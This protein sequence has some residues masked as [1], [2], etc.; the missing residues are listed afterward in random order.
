M[1]LDH[2][3]IRHDLSDLS[4]PRSA[5]G[6]VT[7]AL[8]QRKA[9]GAKAFTV[10]SCD[11]LPSNGALARRILLEFAERVSPDLAAWI[12]ANATFPATM[13]D[14]ITPATTED[15]VARLS[16]EQGYNDLGAVAHEAFRQWVIEDSFADGRPAWDQ[17]GATMVASVEDHELMKLRCL[18]G[19]HST[20]AYLGYL[21]GYET[22]ADCV[23]DPDFAALCEKLWR[24]EIT[25]FLVTPVGENLTEYCAQLLAR[26]RDPSIRHRTWQIAMDGS[27]KLPQ[28]ILGTIRDNL[29]KGECPG[30][31][32]LAV[33]GWM[34]YIGGIDET[35]ATID[36]RDP[37][38]DRLRQISDAASDKVSALLEVEDIFGTDLRDN[39]TFR[40]AVS[41]AYARLIE[42]GAKAAVRNYV[43]TET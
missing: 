15:I 21:A 28:R 6:L 16:A 9:Q 37:L 3:D 40:S 18:N 8:A 10:L 12:S 1:S 31:L 30:G 11:N 22:I 7:A 39:A 34:R 27:Q 4:A 20:L 25:S 43:E 33:A 14:R 23:A 29:A 13:V 24:E 32:C 35:G 38:A 2:P 5:V 26:Y 36:V 41:S 19:T 42:A 17:V